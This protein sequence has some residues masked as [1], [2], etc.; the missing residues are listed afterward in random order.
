[1]FVMFA[2]LLLRRHHDHDLSL[3]AGS[4]CG[5]V[6]KLAQKPR[7]LFIWRLLRVAR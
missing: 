3:I 6:G 4:D 5:L 1:M 7:A 2:H